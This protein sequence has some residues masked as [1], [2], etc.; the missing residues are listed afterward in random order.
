MPTTCKLL[1]KWRNFT[2]SGNTV[3]NVYYVRFRLKVLSLWFDVQRTWSHLES[4]FIGSEDIRKQLPVDSQRFDDID[5]E[6]KKLMKKMSKTPNVV[7]V[8]ANPKWT[9][10]EQMEE[11][12]QGQCEGLVENDKTEKSGVRAQLRS[13]RQSKFA[14]KVLWLCHIGRVDGSKLSRAMRWSNVLRFGL[15]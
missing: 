1:P 8:R 3:L 12:Y 10:V 2:K 6:F 4:I 11:N 7:R 13:C 15:N 9:L 14:S 5:E